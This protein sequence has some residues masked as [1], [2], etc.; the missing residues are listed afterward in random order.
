MKVS[1]LYT[2]DLHEAGSEVEILDDQGNQTGLFIKVMGMDSST[3]RAQAK[4]QQKAY[5]E[6]LRAKK[7]FDDELMTIDS[8]VA[9]TIDWRGTDEKFTKKLCKELYTKAPYIRDQIDTF[10]ADRSNFTTAKPKK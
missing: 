1:E 8:L 3:F 2:T 9:S 6:A 5:M 10:M 4:K 7:D